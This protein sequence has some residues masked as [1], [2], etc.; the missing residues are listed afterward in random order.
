VTN[1]KIPL[2]SAQL[3]YRIEMA[4]RVAEKELN[5]SYASQ[6]RKGKSQAS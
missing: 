2:H 1:P 4:S 6:E 3:S 5:V